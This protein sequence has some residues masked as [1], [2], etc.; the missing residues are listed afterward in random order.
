MY[1]DAFTVYS[2]V[3]STSFNKN[4]QKSLK[5]FFLSNL[6]QLSTAG[7]YWSTTTGSTTSI[8]TFVFALVAYWSSVESENDIS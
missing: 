4:R 5:R 7:H 8:C 1:S 6:F 2:T 3:E